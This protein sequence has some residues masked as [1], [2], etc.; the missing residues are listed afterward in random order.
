[1]KCKTCQT[2]KAS[3]IEERSNI[4]G[5][6]LPRYYVICLECGKVGPKTLQAKTAT[7]IW[8]KDNEDKA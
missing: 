2:D 4:K 1:M 3:L 7:D 6:R 8:E 5:R